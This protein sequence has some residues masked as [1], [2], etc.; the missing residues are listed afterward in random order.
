MLTYGDAPMMPLNGSKQS[1]K[2]PN[3][4][5]SH[6]TYANSTPPYPKNSL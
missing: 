2:R 3:M 5:S 1:L 6:L 4:P